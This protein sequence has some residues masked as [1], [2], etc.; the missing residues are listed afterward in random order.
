[1]SLAGP[2]PVSAV[3]QRLSVLSE[4]RL[5]SGAAGLEA[6]LASPPNAVPAAYV[7]SEEAGEP[8]GDYG[9]GFAQPMTA[10]LKVVLWLRH[11]GDATGAKAV[12]AMETVERAVRTQLRDWSPG[13]PFEPLYILASGNDQFFGNQ[14]IRQVLF[15]T[16]YRDQ[17]MHP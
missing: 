8:S 16:R 13:A 5:V 2:F 9:G 17:E 11:A 3:I 15:R 14:L 7:L 1:M 10:T 6:A 4:L 12:A